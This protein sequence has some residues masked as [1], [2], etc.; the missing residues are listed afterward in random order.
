[1]TRPNRNSGDSATPLSL[2]IHIPFCRARCS[3]CA[4]NTYTG[5]S[6]LI[7]AYVHAL[8]QELDRWGAARPWPALHTIYF[9]GGTPSVLS[10]E[11]VGRI[12]DAVA[13]AFTLAEGLEVTLEANP[14]ALDAGYL[15]SVRRAGVT[16]LSLGAQA[17]QE[18]LLHRFRRDHDWEAV[19][20]SVEAA[21]L[22]GFDNLNLDLIYGTPGQDMA[23]WQ[24][25]LKRA[26][27]LCPEHLSLY[28][29]SVEPGTAMHVWVRRGWLE[30]PDPDRAADMYDH[31]CEV[32]A[33]RGFAH[34]EISNWAQPGF[35]C[36]HNMQYWR[37]QPY[38]GV[39]AG[40]HGYIGERR[41]AVVSAP[42]TYIQRMATGDGQVD[43]LPS[44]AVDL[45]TVEVIGVE[46]ARSE[47]MMLG[48]RLLDEGVS[49]QGF[50]ERFGIS[51]EACYDQQLQRLTASGLLEVLPDRVRLSAGSWLI[52]NFVLEYF[53]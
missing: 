38:L 9:G 21:R 43:G 40:A 41:Y 31:A 46:Q 28:C 11:Q 6:A 17:A 37:N 15:R 34:Y 1:M 23:M 29:L 42:R 50:I 2:Y 5:L 25:T 51:V 36:C 10:S 26:L 18:E 24:E 44:P 16:R 53:V 20:G 8:C 45:E 7:P 48:L 13:Q 30:S 12:L 14:T 4:F 52:S 19:V 39:G 27:A 49:R 47:T 35:E 22:A 33:A 32:L 3:Y